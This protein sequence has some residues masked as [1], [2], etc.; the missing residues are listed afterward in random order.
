MSPW[1][2][3][4]LLMPLLAAQD[5][6]ERVFPFTHAETPQ[7]FQEIATVIRV[8]A[9][10]L[11]VSVDDAQRRLT[12]RGSTDQMAMAAWLF[13][14]LDTVVTP[15]PPDIVKHEYRVP[16]GNDDVIRVFL[17]N[18]NLPVQE[19]QEVATLI[20][21]IAE[22]RRVFV[23]NGPR[24]LAL[25]GTAGQM[26]LAE[27]LVN[28]LDKPSKTEFRLSGT[29]DDRVR[30]F[31]LA[32]AGTIQELQETATLIRATSE[33]R[34][35][36]TYNAPR[37]IAIRGTSEE[38]ALAVWLVD[39]LDKPLDPQAAPRKSSGYHYAAGGLEGF[40]RIFYLPDTPTAQS[41]QQAAVQIRGATKIRRVFTYNKSR[42][43]TLRGTSEQIAMAEQLIKERAKER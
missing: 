10:G 18:P 22:I 26:V 38:L 6:N 27:W 29:N 5:S 3:G 17:L 20:R 34:R 40:V 2:I 39:E 25:R 19:L 41:F 31:H 42:A 37:A 33:V 24:A 11:H 30:V 13:R 43:L 12:V 9:D 35:L 8:M 1:T 36:F 7:S 15:Q 23:Y 32:H 14:E 4:I 28:A 21:A 16:G